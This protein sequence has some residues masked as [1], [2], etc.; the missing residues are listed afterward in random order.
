MTARMSR[1]TSSLSPTTSGQAG[2]REL[3]IVVR[4]A[5][6]RI[7]DAPDSTPCRY[8]RPRFDGRTA[9]RWLRV[10]RLTSVSYLRNRQVR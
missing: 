1:P 3:Q 2:N 7:W 10:T 6:A 8:V 5:A 9:E 4:V